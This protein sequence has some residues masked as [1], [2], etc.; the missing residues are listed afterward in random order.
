MS[1]ASAAL[2]GAS[3]FNHYGPAAKAEEVS[4][5]SNS[6]KPS[7]VCSS[8]ISVTRLASK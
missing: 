7:I 2:L 6:A 1:A 3:G 5:V 8:L 4:T